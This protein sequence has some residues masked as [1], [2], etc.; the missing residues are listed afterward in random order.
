MEKKTTSCNFLYPDVIAASVPYIPDEKPLFDKMKKRFKNLIKSVTPPVHALKKSSFP[1]EN[2]PLNLKPGE[3]VEVKSFEEIS[4]TLDDKQK[5]RG[6]FFMPEMKKFC[7]KKFK[8]FKRAQTIKLE[9]TGEI[10]KLKTPSVFLEGAY[11]TGEE[12]NEWCDRACF[13]F[14]REA[15]LKRIPDV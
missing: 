10:R 2:I 14:W 13:H 11:C 3:W 6:L 12:R 5:N 7:G 4:D 8:V 15:W 1:S 9:S